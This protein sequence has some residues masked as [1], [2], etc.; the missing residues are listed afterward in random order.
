[1]IYYVVSRNIKTF[2]AKIYLKWKLITIILCWR[3]SCSVRW[4][5]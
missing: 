1:M 3:Y 5:C 4:V 2:A